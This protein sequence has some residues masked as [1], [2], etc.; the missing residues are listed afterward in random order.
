VTLPHT[1]GVHVG[2][3]GWLFWLGRQGE[4]LSLY[5]GG[6]RVRLGVW[7]WTRLV[8]RRRRRAAA[9]GARYL[10][11]VAPDKLSVLDDRL[12]PPVLAGRRGI[13]ARLG[14]ALAR[15]PAAES[16]VDLLAPLRAEAVREVAYLRTDTHWTYAGALAATRAVTAALG[17]RPAPILDAPTTLAPHD[18]TFDLGRKLT[19]P[20]S[21]RLLPHVI[22]NQAR[23]VEENVLV[24]L[25]RGQVGHNPGLHVGSRLVYAN[26][27]PEAAP[28]RVV[29]FGDSY[30][31]EEG[32]TLGVMLAECVSELHSVWSA[33]ID[34]DYVARVKP[35]VV[36]H[37]IAE[38]FLRRIPS[39]RIAIDAY[40]AARAARDGAPSRAET[41]LAVA[42]RL[43][44][45]L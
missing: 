35:D 6:W 13:G 16:W 10:Q 8:A 5:R 18:L 24:T 19:P 44:W 25:R 12:L 17:T 11:V 7:A 31:A 34:W 14:D 22:P 21:E 4:M 45:P 28:L 39:D 29:L 3:D 32:Y 1:N 36:I 38:R 23:R 33:S 42:R 30:A 15:G 41:A 43:G 27:S 2:R 40:A 37:E 26:A 9:L 20:A